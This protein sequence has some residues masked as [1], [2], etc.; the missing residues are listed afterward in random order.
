MKDR[1]VSH[2]VYAAWEYEKEEKELNKMSKEGWQLEKGGCF[3]SVYRRNEAERYIYQIDYKPDLE[4]KE[5]YKEIF[6][7]TGWEYINSTYN[8]WHFF[9]KAYVEGMNIDEE[10]IYSD[11]ESLYEMQNRYV[12]MISLF[13]VLYFCLTIMMIICAFTSG[14]HLGAISEIFGCGILTFLFGM[15]RVNIS[16]KRK[17]LKPILDIPMPILYLIGF[18]L[19]LLAVLL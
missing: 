1:K 18:V 5:R 6:A 19:I 17:E 3:H 13:T 11:K 15:A 9:K 4:D 12:R 14:I 16:R 2:K 8:G 7:E 10:K